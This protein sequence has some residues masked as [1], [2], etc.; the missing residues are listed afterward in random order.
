MDKSL[1]PLV[2]VDVVTYIFVDF[3]FQ[4]KRT[5]Q[6][7]CAWSFKFI[8]QSTGCATR[9]IS[10]L[11]ASGSMSSYFKTLRGAKCNGYHCSIKIL[12]NSCEVYV[13][14]L[15]CNPKYI[16]GRGQKYERLL[17]LFIH[18]LQSIDY[19]EKLHP[20]PQAHHSRWYSVQVPCS[21]T[22]CPR[23]E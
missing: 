11:T 15:L 2:C 21:H 4:D 5:I 10:I 12:N 6:R 3:D 18:Y 17:L 1:Y 8:L 13:W 23:F 7:L 20:W 9:D 19:S 22:H 16:C 14:F